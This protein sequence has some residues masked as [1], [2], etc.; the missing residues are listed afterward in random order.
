MCISYSQ[1][2]SIFDVNDIEQMMAMAIKN[3][4]NILNLI[5][6]NFQLG[7]VL[8][9]LIT[10]IGFSFQTYA[11]AETFEEA[12]ISAYNSNPQL[13]AERVRL[14][15]IDETFVQARSQ[16][17]LRS[18]IS[19]D[20]GFLETETT[21]S[22]VFGDSSTASTKLNPRSVQIQFIQPVYQGG[23][24]SALK[25]QAKEGILAARENLRNIEQNILLATATAYADVVRDEEVARIRR[26]NVRVLDRQEIAS[27]ERFRL[28]D[29]TKT[30]VAQSQSR[31]AGAEIGLAQ[32]EAQLAASR[33]AYVEM[34]GY[35]PSELAP[36]P[37]FILPSK[38][39]EAIR[40]ARL[41]NPQL[42]AAQFNENVGEAAISVAK[43]AYRPTITLNGSYQLSENQ[44]INLRESENTSVVAQL[45]I[46]LLTGGLTGSQVR[47]AKHAKTRLKFETRALKRAIDRQVYQ[48]WGQLD[49]IQRSIAASEVQVQAAKEALKG[50]E[51]EKTVGTRS[52][53]DVL[54]A[55]TELLNA[56]LTLLEVQR[57]M[58]VI[59]FQFLTLLGVFDARRLGLSTNYYDAAE[60][61]QYVKFKG[62]DMF[63]D[64]FVPEV[65]QKV[66]KQLPNIPKDVDGV[67]SAT[68][69][70][71]RLKEN[72]DEFARLPTSVGALI[73]E[74]V[75]TVTFQKPNYGPS[76][77]SQT[78]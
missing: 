58:D 4:S 64:Q 50:V 8:T 32:A 38:L 63:V 76:N 74:G 54:D 72:F 19:V 59:S 61:F 36:V 49:A 69:I 47:S 44:S 9:I 2:I 39:E 28:G 21:Q 55:E 42:I 45:R 3:L 27:Q 56:E 73:K 22:S 7:Y 16:E 60:N 51:L 52:T 41:N 30:D 68:G 71:K 14:M 65:I 10:I 31:I 78:E 48:F 34:V 66:G 11:V 17:Q 53:L 15:E 77:S 62:Q 23:R 5:R 37:K 57:N 75:D 29:G 33:A 20:T 67:I 13:I 26:R 25:K 12:L 43:S 1:V 18:D 35:L 6:L 70:P 46:P 24:V 40:L